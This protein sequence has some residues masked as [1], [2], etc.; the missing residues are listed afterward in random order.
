MIINPGFETSQ[1]A[2]L[3]TPATVT[4]SYTQF[5][6]GSHSAYMHVTGNDTALLGQCVSGLQAGKTYQF[7]YWVKADSVRNY[8]LPF[9]RFT[10]DTGNVFDTYFCPNGNVAQW[11][12]VFSR[13]TPPAGADSLIFYFALFQAG[14]VWFDDFSMTEVTDT[15]YHNFAVNTQLTTTPFT[16]VFNA[17]GVGPGNPSDLYNHVQKFQDAGLRYVRTHDFQTAFDYHVIFPDTSKSPLD[18]TAYNFHSTD[19]CI[20]DILNAG[21]KVYFRFGESYGENAVPPADKQ[22]FA[23]VCLQTIKHYNAGWDHGFHYGLDY[24]EIWNEPDIAEFWTGTVEDYI[25]MYAATATKIKQY[26]PSL[27]V[28]GPAVSNIFNESFINPFLDTVV[29]RH[30]PFDFLSYHLYYYPNPYY[31]KLV[32]DYAQSK[33]HQYGLDSVELINSEW[34]TYLY[35]FGTYSIWGMDDPLNAASTASALTYMQDTHIGKM[36]RY[37][38]DNYWFGMVD[39]YDNWRYAGYVFKAYHE[40]AENNVRLSVS[41]ADS[42]G[43]T[44]VASHNPSGSLMYT[45]VSDNSSSA[46][47]YHLSFNNLGASSWYYTIYRINSNH[48]L[49]AVDS[50]SISSSQPAITERVQPPFVDYVVLQL[51]TGISENSDDQ[52][53]VFPVPATNQLF[54]TSPKTSAFTFDLLELSGKQILSYSF[55]SNKGSISLSGIPAGVYFARITDENGNRFVKKVI[56]LNN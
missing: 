5:H 12:K 11:T 50:G 21:G 32:N 29:A 16:D 13:F 55:K 14:N 56:I 31:Y 47:G 18:S 10:S 24:F 4:L 39:W 28:G 49:T 37:A 9:L 19:S 15:T 40:L 1:N 38:F 17:N 20:A 46:N 27:N 48:L 7:E 52:F 36:I 41:G 25:E 2:W 45:M 53:S 35:S 8:V 51:T 26:D 3:F 34:N 43:A 42:L 44:L 23:D 6:G 22:K 33:L 54:V 30:L